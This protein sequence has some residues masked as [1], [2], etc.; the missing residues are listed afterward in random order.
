M[1]Y[2]EETSEEEITNLLTYSGF[3]LLAFELVKGLVVNPIKAFYA[4]VEFGKGLP[5]SSYEEDVLSR[6]KNQ[7]EA[8]LL[9]LRDFMQAIDTDDVLTVQALRKH[10]N[11][12]A[13][14]LPNMMHDLDIEKHIALLEN[15]DKVLFKLSN[16]NAYMNIGAG[17][18]FKNLGIDWN[19][20][21]GGEYVLFESIVQKVKLLKI[22]SMA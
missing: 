10:R 8:C 7:F 6:H 12:L 3:I 15:T 9:Y 16:H 22:K 19:T 20:V 11:E 2:L 13:H 14:D 1:R 17:P 18:K 4:D 5:F 21:K